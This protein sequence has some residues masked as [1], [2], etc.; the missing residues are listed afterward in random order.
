M[1]VQSGQE[2]GCF[3]PRWPIRG[4]M[5][6][7]WRKRGGGFE[8][9]WT[10]DD[11]LW[12]PNVH[13]EKPA[14]LPSI[15]MLFFPR[16]RLPPV[17]KHARL[18]ATNASN[19]SPPSFNTVG[20]YE[21]FDRRVKRLQR[22]KAALRDGGERSRVVDYVRD[23]VADRMMERFMVCL[24]HPLSTSR[25]INYCWRTSKGHSAQSSMSVLA[26]DISLNY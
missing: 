19:A 16:L 18:L 20:P 25:C 17:S 13:R 14:L 3:R 6:R 2:V 9:D 23:E 15:I 5:G 7:L 24:Y 26:R 21:V 12:V 8:T 11:A 4:E 22:D 10:P 1:Q